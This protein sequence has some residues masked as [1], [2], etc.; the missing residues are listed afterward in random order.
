MTDRD[1]LETEYGE[2][3]GREQCY[4]K[5]REK[6]ASSSGELPRGTKES[7]FPPEF[8]SG[9]SGPTRSLLGGVGGRRA[10]EA[11]ADGPQPAKRR[12]GCALPAVQKE[13]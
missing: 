8:Q 10:G 12:A 13:V 9:G 11:G 5:P 6:G 2:M 4:A 3:I 1:V 7:G